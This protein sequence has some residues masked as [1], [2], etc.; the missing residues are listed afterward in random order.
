M[1]VISYLF[2]WHCIFF[3][4]IYSFTEMFL[5]CPTRTMNYPKDCW[6]YSEEN[7]KKACLRGAYMEES[8]N[9]H[10]QVKYVNVS[11]W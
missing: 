7:M 9:K 6:Y 2:H 11:Y 3:L 1:L 8:E 5:E 4:K 10:K